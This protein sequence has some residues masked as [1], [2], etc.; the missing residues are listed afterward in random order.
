MVVLAPAFAG[1][2]AAAL[3]RLPAAGLPLRLART[4]VRRAT[5]RTAAT[6][7]ALALGLAVVTFMTVV[8]TSA[9]AGIAGAVDDILRAELIVESTRGEMLGGLS[10]HVYE[11][12]R[13][14]EGVQ[15]VSRRRSGHWKDEGTTWAVTA[16]DPETFPAVVDLRMVA[17]NLSSLSAGGIVLAENIASGRGL[18]V[19]D[20]LPMEFS[21]GGEQHLEVV[22][23]AEAGDAAMT[24]GYLISLETYAEL[25]S[26]DVD[27]AV[28]LALEDGA[29]VEAVRGD[30]EA[31]LA[32]FPTAAIHDQAD[33]K[34]SMTTMLDSMLGLVT[35]LL[36][37]AVLIALLGITNALALS[38]VERTREVGMLRAV[39]MTR[40]Q[41]HWMVRAEAG[42]TATVGGLMGVAL[43]IA[44]AAAAVRA[45][46]SISVLPLTVPAGQL[47]MYLVVAALGGV[48]AGLIPGRRAARMDV[49]AAIATK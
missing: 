17:G 39:G 36:L 22:G 5:R 25:F 24:A 38:I 45:L 43:G 11:R 2:A 4:N 18:D 15:T 10:P 21:R 13:D 42:L 44:L 19:G 48:A 28:Y 6:S 30:V 9:K 32:D 7:T 35:V 20:T 33:A 34:A 47:A 27:Y 14:I 46:G 23:I 1:Q 26:E 16:I 29:D 8:A 12:V 3:G 37:L 49:L 41:L 40:R 31:A